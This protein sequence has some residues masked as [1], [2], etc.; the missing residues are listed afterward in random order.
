MNNKIDLK[1]IYDHAWNQYNTYYQSYSLYTSKFNMVGAVSSVF[2]LVLITSAQTWSLLF[3][4]PIS[5]LLIPFILTL[6]N[7]NLNPWH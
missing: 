3:Y 5:F 4:I 6:I 7:L 2:I 1:L